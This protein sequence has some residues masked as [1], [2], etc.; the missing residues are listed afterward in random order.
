[1][2]THINRALGSDFD[3]QNFR[4][5]ALY[6]EERGRIEMHIESMRAQKVR[7][8]D[9][10]IPFQN[11]ERIHT[12]NSYKY[13]LEEFAALANAAGWQVRNVWQDDDKLF[14]V[15]YLSADL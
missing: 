14:S 3:L 1:L 5:V 4:H 12:E 7:I 10:E 11:G 13:S 15:Q 9:E 8:G 2:L 6:N